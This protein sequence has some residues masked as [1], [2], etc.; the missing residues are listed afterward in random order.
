MCSITHKSARAYVEVFVNACENESERIISGVYDDEFT[1]PNEPNLAQNSGENLPNSNENALNLNKNTE[2][3]ASNSN[4]SIA[5]SVDKNDDENA[6]SFDEL[7][8][9]GVLNL[10]AKNSKTKATKKK[11][12]KEWKF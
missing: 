9:S 12:D 4:Q 7:V 8:Q 11:K 10:G 1:A 3:L 2:N 6:P 5:E